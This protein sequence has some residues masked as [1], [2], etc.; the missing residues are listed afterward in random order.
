MDKGSI[1]LIKKRR[2]K[3]VRERDTTRDWTWKV[4]GRRGR[5]G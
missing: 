5:G 1:P 2:E 4:D 3:K